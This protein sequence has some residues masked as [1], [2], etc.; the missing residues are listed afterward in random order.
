MDVFPP[1]ADLHELYDPSCEKVAVIVGAK[2]SCQQA[3][4]IQ[5]KCSRGPRFVR[6]V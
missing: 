1:N 5:V 6:P 4:A 3:Q 2:R